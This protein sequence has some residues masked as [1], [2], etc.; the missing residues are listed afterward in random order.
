MGSLFACFVGL[1]AVPGY[2]SGQRRVVVGNANCMAVFFSY[3]FSSSDRGVLV[4]YGG[5]GISSSVSYRSGL[6]D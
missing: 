4:W 2:G 3:F 6:C 1:R 5:V